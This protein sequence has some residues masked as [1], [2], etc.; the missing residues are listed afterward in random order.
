MESRSPA[1]S[2]YPAEIITGDMFVF[3][4][5]GTLATDPETEDNK[6]RYAS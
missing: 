2:F 6:L 3:Q 1:S 4:T 5:A